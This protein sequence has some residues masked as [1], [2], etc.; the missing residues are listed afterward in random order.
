VQKAFGIIGKKFAQL[1][2][3]EFFGFE[4]AGHIQMSFHDFNDFMNRRRIIWLPYAFE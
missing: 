2:H 4:L 1:N 3:G